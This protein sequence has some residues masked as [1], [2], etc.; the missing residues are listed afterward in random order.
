MFGIEFYE[1]VSFFRQLGLA[2]A[3]AASLWGFVFIYISRKK[4][5][6]QTR[7]I[8]YEWV[9][10]RMMFVLYGAA[11]VAIGAWGVLLATIP[12]FAHEGI[13]LIPKT[14]EIY[15]A[16]LKTAPLYIGWAV[17][18]LVGLLWKGVRN[19]VTKSGWSWFY[20]CN[21]ALV[22]IVISYYV[23]TAGAPLGDIV[24]YAFHGFHSIFTL[25]TVLVLDIMFLS[26]KSSLTLQQH[27]FPLFPKI[28]KVIWVGLALDSLSVLI[29]YPEAVILSPRFFFAQTVVGIL[30]INGVLL[31]GIL[32]RKILDN[33]EKGRTELHG[34]WLLFADIAGAISITSW[35]SITFVDFF[36]ELTLSYGQL[37]L[38]YVCVIATLFI[39]HAIWE[40]FDTDEPDT[41]GPLK[42]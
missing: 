39:G 11:L 8:I 19:S 35:T 32:T 27:I 7:S 41:T 6:T 5:Q 13:T 1:L 26:S 29:I 22:S 9:A 16:A 15:D 18:L 10:R 24:F 38:I 12:T 37:F 30:I 17:L 34:K 42:A 23:H 3:G 21:F 40:R 25:G 4:G 31:S 14:H 36:D 33:L 28:S 2:V 20:I